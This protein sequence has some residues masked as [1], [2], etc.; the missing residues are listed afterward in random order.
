VRKAAVKA[1]TDS[2]WAGLP[3]L[4]LKME[5]LADLFEDR[6]TRLGSGRSGEREEEKMTA[7][8][9]SEARDIQIMIRGL[10]R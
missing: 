1:G 4:Q 5:D 7:L 3:P 8:S 2:V 6:Q 9:V 10:P